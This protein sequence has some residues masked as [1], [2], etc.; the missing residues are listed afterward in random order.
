MSEM[1]KTNGAQVPVRPRKRYRGGQPGNTNAKKHVTPLS[2]IKRKIRDLK[3]RM[4][5]ALALVPK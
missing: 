3:R 4:K 2:T 1:C 5:V